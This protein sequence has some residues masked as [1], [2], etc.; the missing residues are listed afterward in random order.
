MLISPSATETDVSVAHVCL[1]LGIMILN[2]C[3]YVSIVGFSTNNRSEGNS[4]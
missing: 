3:F 4:G 1:A 2:K